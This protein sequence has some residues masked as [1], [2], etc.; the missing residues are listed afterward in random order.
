MDYHKSFCNYECTQCSEVCPTGAIMPLN[1]EQKKITQTG[2]VLFIK[3]SCVVFTDETSCGACSEHC[4]TKAVQMVAYKGNLTI[5]HTNRDICIGCGACEYACPVR[6]YRAIYV[7][8]NNIHMQAQK[9][10]EEK[11]EDMMLEEFPF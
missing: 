7:D 6:P 1:V 11:L 2:V 9:P 10:K 8:G 5:P 4:P 3:E